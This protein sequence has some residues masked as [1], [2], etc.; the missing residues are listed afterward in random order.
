MGSLGE[1]FFLLGS[2]IENVTEGSPSNDRAIAPR[3]Q[4]FLF[5]FVG[6]SVARGDVSGVSAWSK[7]YVACQH[8]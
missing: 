7:R 4:S 2:R 6:E 1:G 5:C 8:A 3:T